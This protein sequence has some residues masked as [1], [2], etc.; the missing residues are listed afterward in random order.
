MGDLFHPDAKD[1]WIQ[2]VFDSIYRYRHHKYLILTKRPDRMLEL[3]D[4][5]LRGAYSLS[6][7]SKNALPDHLWVGVT[8]ENQQRADERIPILLQIPAAVRFVSVEPMLGPVGLDEIEENEGYLNSLTGV[9]HNVL[10]DYKGIGP[11]I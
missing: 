8:A 11:K 6:N 3:L 10:A 5:I 7:W 9:C 4:T 1:K 2:A